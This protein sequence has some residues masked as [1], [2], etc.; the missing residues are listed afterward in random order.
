MM[1]GEN[2]G[3]EMEKKLED[4]RERK[5]R[6]MGGGSPEK[7]QK[8]HESGK[9]TARERLEH[10]FDPGTFIEYGL[11]AGPDCTL[12]GLDQEFAP[13]DG[14]ITGFG[15][16]DGRLVWAVSQD[17]TVLGGS[18]GNNH[19]RKI[20]RAGE[21]AAKGGYPCVYFWDGGGGRIQEAWFTDLYRCMMVA[22]ANSGYIPTVS[23]ICGA[24]AG[25][26][27]YTP[28]LND[29]V[30]CVDQ[31]SRFYLCGP[32]VIRRATGEVVDDE[33]LAGAYTENSIS[34]NAHQW[35]ASDEEAI[36]HVKAYLSYM[37]SNCREKP[38]AVPYQDDINRCV[39]ELDHILPDAPGKSYDVMDV[40][41]LIA[42]VD[43]LYEYQPYWAQ[44]LVTCFGRVMGE[45][46][47]FIAN[48]SQVK[49]GCF[50]IDASDKFARFVDILDC[51]QIPI[52]TLTDTPG[53]L[54]GKDQEHGGIIRHGAKTL[55]AIFR[56]TV[57]KIQIV[58][59]KQIG[60]GAL[61]M[62][63]NLLNL[64]MNLYWPTL[65]YGIMNPRSAC[66]IITAKKRREN[67]EHEEEIL[68]EA[69]RIF[70]EAR[71]PYAMA[72]HLWADDII[73]PNQTRMYL[74]RALEMLKKKNEEPV[75]FAERRKKHAVSPR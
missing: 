30:I 54:P 52:I 68:K 62:G 36:A 37:P 13:G 69:I 74:I 63:M 9:M 20:C 38:P 55:E 2:M 56:A 57:P 18:M 75:S 16:V 71:T 32:S 61:P 70:T 3:I 46:V 60:G 31:T 28:I 33:D 40:I 72:G 45:P 58:L 47:G 44:N 27:A 51:Y 19:C 15:K 49:A 25:G 29:F 7:I 4:L 11:F 50:D 1:G 34:G 42:D 48:Q 26:A 73:E 35:A 64:D 23:V 43:S 17:A 8:Q 12:H 65:N 5:G 10:L 59:R 39:P 66:E 53:F 24:C 67:P 14:V 22:A 41:R 21:E 6:W